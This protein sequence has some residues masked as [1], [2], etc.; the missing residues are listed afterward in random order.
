MHMTLLQ[1]GFVPVFV[2]DDRNETC[3]VF[4]NREIPH[5]MGADS[6]ARWNRHESQV[7]FTTK[8]VL[9]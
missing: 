1:P 3:G 9:Y 5:E 6:I 2:N 7:T 4:E 8:I